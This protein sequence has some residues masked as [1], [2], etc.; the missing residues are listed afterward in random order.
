MKPK[1]RELTTKVQRANA[2]LTVLDNGR[3][4][5][6]QAQTTGADRVLTEAL[7]DVEAAG[8]LARQIREGGR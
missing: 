5:D 2:A 4:H 1:I 6:G 8:E 3:R 7:A